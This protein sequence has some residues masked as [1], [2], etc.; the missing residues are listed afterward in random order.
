MEEEEHPEG[1]RPTRVWPLQ[2][3]SRQGEPGRVRDP[4]ESHQP[5]GLVE[6]VGGVPLTPSKDLRA[7][8]VSLPAGPA[9]STGRTGSLSGT[10]IRQPGT[11]V[12]HSRTRW[13]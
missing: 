9:G 11:R 7:A 4:R 2:G 3:Q 6:P 1:P 13:N 5:P 10:R 8:A 12:N